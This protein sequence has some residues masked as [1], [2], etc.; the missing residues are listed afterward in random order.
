MADYNALKAVIN[1]YIKQNGVQAITGQILN[2]VL[3]G[4]VNALGKGYT[5]VGEATPSTDPGTMTGPASYIAHTAGVYEHF[6]NI[7]V[8]PGEVAMLIYN[9]AQWHKETIASL[10]AD[11][12]VDG[13]TGTPSVDV[14]WVN[15]RLTFAFH[16][17]KGEQGNPGHTGPAAG[18]G[19]PTAAVDGNVGTPGV[20]VSASGP[21]TAKVFSFQFTNLKGAQGDQGIQGPEGPTGP[22]GVTSVVVTVDNTSGNPTCTASLVSG[23][24]TLA[25]TGLKGAQG[26]T[27][28]SVAYPFTLVNNLTTDDP[29]QA[30]SAAM[31]V[32][33][34]S[35]VS[36]LEAEINGSAGQ[37]TTT[38]YSEAGYIKM[39]DGSI[40]T[41]NTWIHT[42]LLP[43]GNI[44]QF[45][46]FKANSAVANIAFYATSELSS[47]IS[48][49]RAGADANPEVPTD[50]DILMSVVT[51]P[52]GAN[53]IAFSTNGSN[54]ANINVVTQGA[55]VRGLVDD[56]SDLED[57]VEDVEDIIEDVVLVTE[58]T[59][60]NTQKE[61]ARENI[62]AA[63]ATEVD[64]ALNGTTEQTTT[65][66]NEAGYIKLA[67]G[68]IVTGNT[69]IHTPLIPVG[70][71]IEFGK[72]KG[73]GSVAAVA[74]YATQELSSY[75]SGITGGASEGDCP[76][77]RM[78]SMSEITIPS[79]TNYVAFSTN[80]NNY[81]VLT[82]KT[83][84]E[85]PGLNDKVADLEERVEDLEEI[86]DVSV[87]YTAQVLTESQKAQA[88]T[89]IGITDT[90]KYVHFSLDDCT[91]W[92][93]LIDNENNYDSCFDNSV[94]A[95]LKVFHDSYGLCFTLNCFIVSG[96]QSIEDVP[97]KW[98]SEFA[99][100]KDWLRFAFHGTDTNETFDNTDSAVLKGYYDT[101]VTAIFKMT[102]TYD[103]IDR[104]TRLSS[105]SGNIST[106]IP[107][108]RDTDCGIVGLLTNDRDVN[109]TP[110]N[111]YG[112]SPTQ[113]AY[114]HSHDRMYDNTT[115][116]HFIRTVRR[117]E[118]YDVVPSALN[119]AKYA[120]FRP[121]VEIFWHETTGWA[122][123]YAFTTWLK[124]WFDWLAEN[125]YKNA[126]TSDILLI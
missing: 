42:P 112:L 81:P 88:R 40:A 78:V 93:D 102:G 70:T 75:I 71:V 31:G 32:Q 86:Q 76:L 63:S 43:I 30:L 1:A 123:D 18:F 12:T 13:T 111:S 2:G 46:K 37:Q 83:E 54:Y 87:H 66:Y 59:F 120:N 15:G 74:F 69:W 22:A 99:A 14:S 19:T 38:Q 44:V 55:S 47:Y 7:A 9:E 73:H 25:F 68:S 5:V 101:F 108:I 50:S 90:N 82:V 24:L 92:A 109:L 105:Y 100:N 115:M 124:P 113:N 85:T 26:D 28:S 107:A 95:R 56:V 57:R 39:T 125:G 52:D 98:A 110:G 80:G 96:V 97:D 51:V 3:I 62:D 41:G 29:T 16:D 58:Q 114:I 6:D 20:S 116:L 53:Y 117:L 118:N 91:F 35:E 8:D 61:Q 122:S 89:N 65:N 60:T 49:I 94:L 10:D 17:I 11:A 27:G 48:G 84:V 36:Q 45:G 77:D 72:I 4:M 106:N 64:E 34:E 119:T 23:V 121:I 103:C 33:L 67:D 79:G 104:I 126:F 21:D